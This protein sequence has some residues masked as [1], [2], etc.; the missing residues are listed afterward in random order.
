[1]ETS[2]ALFAAR[3]KSA[4]LDPAAMGWLDSGYALAGGSFPIRVSGV[5]VVAAVSAS[6]LSS[7]DDHDLVVDGLR[8]LLAAR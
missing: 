4:Q 7:D 1:M 8:A 6:G 5:G 2:S 3:M